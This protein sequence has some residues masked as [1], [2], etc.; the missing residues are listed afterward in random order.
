MAWSECGSNPTIKLSS[1][2]GGPS[3]IVINSGLRCALDLFIDSTLRQIYWRNSGRNLIEKSS[4][5][6]NNRETVVLRASVSSFTLTDR[7]IYWS[8]SNKGSIYRRHRTGSNNEEL[9]SRELQ[10]PALLMAYNANSVS[11]G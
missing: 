9:V 3:T 6:G 8:D 5:N 11:G 1:M 10:T 7:F 2:T 4:L